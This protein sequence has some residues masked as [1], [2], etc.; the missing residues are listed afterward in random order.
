MKLTIMAKSY[1]YTG[2][3]LAKY[4]LALDIIPEFYDPDFVVLMLTPEICDVDTERLKNALKSLERRAPITSLPPRITSP[5][6]AISPRRAILSDSETIGVKNALGR[7]LASVTV[8]CPPAV[9][10]VISG[11]IIDEDAIKC[12]NYYGITECS[13]VK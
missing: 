12:F 13:V 4:L 3:E 1:G 10:I 11:E 7:T 6:R 2:I 5:K 8:G 9:P